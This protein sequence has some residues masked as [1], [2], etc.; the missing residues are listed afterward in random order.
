MVHLFPLV[1]DE[2]A[3]AMVVLEPA[4]D[5]WNGRLGQ[6]NARVEGRAR[7]GMNETGRWLVDRLLVQYTITLVNTALVGQ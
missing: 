6:V 3:D 4:L 5:A 1:V 2:E 7:I